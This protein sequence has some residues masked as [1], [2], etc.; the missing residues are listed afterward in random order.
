MHA[1]HTQGKKCCIGWEIGS[2]HYRQSHHGQVKHQTIF[3]I[4]RINGILQSNQ[5]AIK[6][7]GRTGKTAKQTAKRRSK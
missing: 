2:N 7:K 5:K 3:P 1:D 6:K 4:S